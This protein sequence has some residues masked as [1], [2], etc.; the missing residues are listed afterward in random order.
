MS[1]S[2]AAVHGLSEPS[3]W[4]RDWAHLVETGGAVL[5]VASGAGRHARFFASRGHPVTAID[6]DPAALDLLRDAP[7]VTP[8][9]ADL[10]GAAWPLPADAKFAAV[11]V[12]NYLHRPL[13]ESLLQALAPGGV[14]VYETFA[15]GNESVGK[16]SNPAFLLA[17]GELLERVR[18]HLRVVA[19]QDGYLAQPRPAY[20][21]R[22]CA[23]LEAERSD[24]PMQAASP[25]CYGLAG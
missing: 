24:D 9:V 13:F 18:G 25:R 20:V 11:V 14:L 15:Q 17:P 5:D 6:R 8:L 19:F 23:I 2:A 22:I 21:Q 10:E 12:T 4:V 7:L 16:P 1:T 3:P